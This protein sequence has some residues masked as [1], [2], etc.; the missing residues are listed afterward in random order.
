MRIGFIGLGVMGSAMV[1]HLAKGGHTLAFY[2]LAPDVIRRVA[3]RHQGALATKSAALQSEE[4]LRS[5]GAQSIVFGAPETKNGRMTLPVT[6]QF[7]AP[8]V[9]YPRLTA[10]DAVGLAYFSI[11]RS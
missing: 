5:L 10:A 9:E 1:G 6:I 7:S 3:R 11:I 4:S 8:C 2:D